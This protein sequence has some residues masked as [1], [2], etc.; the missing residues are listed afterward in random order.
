MNSKTT[1]IVSK[2]YTLPNLDAINL[3]YEKEKT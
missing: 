3:L 1:S 2:I